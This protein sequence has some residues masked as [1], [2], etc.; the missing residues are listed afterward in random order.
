MKR[1]TEHFIF[2]YEANVNE[3]RPRARYSVKVLTLTIQ[4]KYES[5]YCAT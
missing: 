5:T 1:A 2:H 3:H 4:T